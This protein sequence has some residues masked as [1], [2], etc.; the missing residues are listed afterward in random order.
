VAA[1]VTGAAGDQDCHVCCPLL[2]LRPI[3]T[4]IR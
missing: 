1:D 4:R 3:P 2:V